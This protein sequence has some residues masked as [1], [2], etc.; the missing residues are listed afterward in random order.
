M[1]DE[2]EKSVTIT[3]N[4]KKK[5]HY[6]RVIR[7]KVVSQKRILARHGDIYNPSTWEAKAGQFL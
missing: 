2:F 7:V 4:I 6:V 5:T 3:Q 1:L